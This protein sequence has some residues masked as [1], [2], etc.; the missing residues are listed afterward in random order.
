MTND[1]EN[2]SIFFTTNNTWKESESNPGLH[3][4]KTEP[5]CRNCGVVF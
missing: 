4:Y 1:K 3:N 5:K 2:Q